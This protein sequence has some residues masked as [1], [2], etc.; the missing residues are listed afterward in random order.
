MKESAWIASRRDSLV[1]GREAIGD[2]DVESGVDG[3]S[4]RMD[5]WHS[6]CRAS[7]KTT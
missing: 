2:V 7:S 1:S 4:A 5:S 3:R 6:G